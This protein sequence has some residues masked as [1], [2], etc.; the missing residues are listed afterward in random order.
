YNIPVGGALFAMEVILG[1]FALEIFGPIVVAS[2]IATLISRAFLGDLPAYA[3]TDYQLTS[4]WE[5]LAYLG[6]GIV[7]AI[8]SVIFV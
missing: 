6:L 2:V 5:L 1:N 3:A 8:A 4:P 7:G